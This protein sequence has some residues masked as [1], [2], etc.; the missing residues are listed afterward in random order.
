MTGWFGAAGV[1]Y[2]RRMQAAPDPTTQIQDLVAQVLAQAP[3][4]GN[5]QQ[6]RTKQFLSQ[7][8]H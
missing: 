3:P 5:P 8:L 4:G 2:Y 6:E 7:I 1:G